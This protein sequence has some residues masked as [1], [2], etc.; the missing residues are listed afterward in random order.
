MWVRKGHGCILRINWKG[1][2]KR[3]EGART[4]NG[5]GGAG[6]TEVERPREGGDRPLPGSPG[7]GRRAGAAL[8]P[9]GRREAALRA[10]YRGVWCP[11]R[12]PLKKLAARRSFLCAKPSLWTRLVRFRARGFPRRRTDF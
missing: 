2:G 10:W 4:E 3:G 1:R 11:L 12:E 9:G 5:A 8:T 6:G 7:A